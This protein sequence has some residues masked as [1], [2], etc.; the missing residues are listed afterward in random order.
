LTLPYFTAITADVPKIAFTIPS[1]TSTVLPQARMEIPEDFS[2][3][4][5]VALKNS[6]N[7]IFITFN[8]IEDTFR[9]AYL[10]YAPGCNTFL[11]PLGDGDLGQLSS[12]YTRHFKQSRNSET[13]WLYSKP[14]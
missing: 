5:C 3:V 14:D 11:L 13:I 4:Q 10:R 1:S 7:N 2:F 8:I 12:R 9:I 6:K